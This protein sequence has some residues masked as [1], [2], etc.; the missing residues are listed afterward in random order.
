MAATA[1]A[2]FKANSPSWS[3][4]V[5]REDIDFISLP[6]KIYFSAQGDKITLDV[7]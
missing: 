6:R 5:I 1:F 3:S 2:S 7:M 4:S